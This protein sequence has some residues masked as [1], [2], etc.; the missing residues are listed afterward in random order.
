MARAYIACIELEERA[1]SSGSNLTEDLS[2]L[3]SDLHALFVEALRNRSI[4]FVDR[5]D[6]ARIAYEIISA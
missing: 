2:N 1:Q 4:A 3:R 5:A 6:A